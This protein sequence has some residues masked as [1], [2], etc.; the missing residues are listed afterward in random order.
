MSAPVADFKAVPQFGPSPL[1]VQFQDLSTGNPTSWLWKFD[2]GGDAFTTSTAQNPTHTFKAPPGAPWGRYVELKVTNTEG[3]S[4]KFV[5]RAFP[6][7][8]FINPPPVR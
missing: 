5:G 3:E 1:V 7:G 6:G 2:D 8:V 4:T